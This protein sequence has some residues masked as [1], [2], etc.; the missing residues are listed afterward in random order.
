MWKV[1][2]EPTTSAGTGLWNPNSHE[3]RPASPVTPNPAAAHSL[4]LI[5]LFRSGHRL[6][7]LGLRG[8]GR[9]GRESGRQGQAGGGRAAKSGLEIKESGVWERSKRRAT[10]V[11]ELN[12]KGLQELKSGSPMNGELH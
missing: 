2:A 11:L 5:P 4:F 1:C 7:M 12:H 6:R 8:K 10:Q 3:E 9:G